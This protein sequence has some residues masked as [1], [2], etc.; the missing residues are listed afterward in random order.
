MTYE[1]SAVRQDPEFES[2]TAAPVA[3]SLGATIGGLDISQPLTT[4]AEREIQQ[5][6]VH[7]HVLFFHGLDLTPAQH[8]EFAKVFGEVQM[9]GTIPRLEEQPEVKKQE[10]TK[11]AGIG[12]DVNMHADDTFV[13]V[14]SRCSLLYGVDMPPAGG[15]TIWINTEAAYAA[16][17]KP[18][19]K[20]LEGLT[21]VHDLA[22]RFGLNS[23]GNPDHKMRVKIEEHYPPVE[24]PV[25][26][27][28]PESG[29]KSIFVNEMVTTRI[30]GVPEDES[31]LLLHYLFNHLKKPLFQVRLHWPKTGTLVVWDNRS[32]QHL[33]L[34]DF[35]PQYRLNHRV[36]IK[37]TVRPQAP[38]EALRSVA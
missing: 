24:H 31:Q 11:Q 2:F 14:P 13:E 33:I 5:A 18:M 36:A 35:Q 3:G 27:V 29:R 34:P 38:A 1:I 4:V 19:Q 17:S 21:A 22:S 20:M 28:H 8:T 30:N 6:L 10:Y 25:I 15:D 7:F 16:L 23:W 12:G 9:G 32:T 26:R 37:D